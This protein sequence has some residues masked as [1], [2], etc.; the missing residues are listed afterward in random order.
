MNRVIRGISAA[1]LPVLILSGF[2]G[3]AANGQ[4][5]SSSFGIEDKRIEER[6]DHLDIDLQIPVLS[7][8]DVAE[9][10][11]TMIDESISKARKEIEDAASLMEDDGSQLAGLHSGYLYSKS[12][13]LV[14]LWLMMDNYSGGAHGLYW[15]EPYTFNTNTNEIYRFGDLFRDGN[16]S[17]ALVTDQIISKIQENPDL[18]FPSVVETVEQYHNDYSFLINGNYLVVFFQLYE[19]APYAG[20]IQFFPFK[21]EELKDILKPEIYEAMKDSEPIDMDGT[22]LEYWNQN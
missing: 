22:I 15:I 5:V 2:L 6:T 14:S 7:G 1:I 8:F 9:T 13:E 21:A 10:I 18:Y 12:G 11:N 16:A 20:G 3:C 17:A 19:I 4:P